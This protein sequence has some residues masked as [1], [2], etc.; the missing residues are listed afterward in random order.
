MRKSTYISQRVWRAVDEDVRKA[1]L[2]I[3]RIHA[4][5]NRKDIVGKFASD[6]VHKLHLVGEYRLVFLFLRP[7][8]PTAIWDG[9]E[10]VIPSKELSDNGAV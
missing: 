4:M 6:I 2:N 1:I 9:S 5:G 10:W 3:Y 7:D 8:D